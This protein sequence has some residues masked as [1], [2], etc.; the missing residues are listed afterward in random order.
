MGTDRDAAALHDKA[1]RGFTLSEAERHQLDAWYATQDAQESADLSR[2][3]DPT[4]QDGLHNQ[5]MA[6]LEQFQRM[7]REMQELAAQGA[8]LRQEI[9][10]L[11]AELAQRDGTRVA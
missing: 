8:A 6:A 7:S 11:R 2:Q 10:T 9:A 1:T 3:S 5:T 4:P